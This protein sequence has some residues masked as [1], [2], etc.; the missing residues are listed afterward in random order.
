RLHTG[1]VCCIL[2]LGILQGSARGPVRP[3]GPTKDGHGRPEKK[4]RKKLAMMID[5]LANRNQPPK[6]VDDGVGKL[7]LFPAKY[8]W[9]EYKRVMSALGKVNR[10]KTPEMWEEL[11]RRTGDQRYCL[12]LKWDEDHALGNRTVGTFCSHFAYNWLVGVCN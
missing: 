12:T 6:L 2:V 11:L 4:G 3:A 7:P 8:D 5:A 9:K 1:L 10:E